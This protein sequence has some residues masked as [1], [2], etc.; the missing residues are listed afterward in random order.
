MLCGSWAVVCGHHLFVCI[1][2]GQPTYNTPVGDHDFV[3]MSSDSWQRV[4]GL[5]YTSAD[6]SS[7]PPLLEH[8]HCFKTSTYVDNVGE[9]LKLT[10]SDVSLKWSSV[11][12]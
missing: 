10:E 5:W 4:W 3:I 8:V 7:L 1:C 11:S 2:G 12:L 6:H 9:W